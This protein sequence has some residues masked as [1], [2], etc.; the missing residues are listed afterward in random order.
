MK[1]AGCILLILPDEVSLDG[2]AT[3]GS[4]RRCIAK[5]HK[6]VNQAMRF[7]SLSRVL[8]EDRA[9][10]MY[11]WL[12][13]K[14]LGILRIAFFYLIEKISNCIVNIITTVPLTISF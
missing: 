8:L 1:G 2:G 4:T 12:R 5:C 3:R 7:Q 10:R 14:I 13:F 6:L 11:F 9:F